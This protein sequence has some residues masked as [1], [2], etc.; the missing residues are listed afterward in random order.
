MTFSPGQ[1]RKQVTVEV[2]GDTIQEA[3]ETFFVNLGSP[4]GATLFDNS[5][6]LGTLLDDD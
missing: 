3:D 4:S 1:T 5:Q 6:G 2:T